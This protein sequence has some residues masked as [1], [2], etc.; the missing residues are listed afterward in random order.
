MCSSVLNT[1]KFL[2]TDI[3]LYFPRQKEKKEIDISHN[4]DAP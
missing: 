4:L 3:V 2:I 1:F